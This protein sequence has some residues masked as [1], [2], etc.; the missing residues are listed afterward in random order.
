MGLRGPMG[1]MALWAWARAPYGPTAP[2]A[3]PSPTG[4]GHYLHPTTRLASY[5]ETCIRLQDLHPT[6]RLAS[7]YKTCIRLQ[8]LHPIAI[9]LASNHHKTC[10]L[11]QDLHP[12]TRLASYYKTGILLQD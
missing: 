12:T 2:A 3:A 10:I 6:T 11:L 5:Y 9:T 8:D 4:L 1:L 7:Y